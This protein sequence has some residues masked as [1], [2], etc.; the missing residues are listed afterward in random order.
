MRPVRVCSHACIF[1]YGLTYST[2]KNKTKQNKQKTKKPILMSSNIILFVSN[3]HLFYTKLINSWNT[4][5]Y[6][7]ES[8]IEAEIRSFIEMGV[9]GF[10][11]RHTCMSKIDYSLETFQ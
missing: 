7:N 6:V 4:S 2:E 3:R 1:L 11:T 5:I 8:I 9:F 10:N